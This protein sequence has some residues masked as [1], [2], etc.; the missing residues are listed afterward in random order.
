MSQAHK[1]GWGAVKQNTL[2]SS[3]RKY[4]GRTTSISYTHD[5][6][7][8]IFDR[9]LDALTWLPLK[10]WLLKSCSKAQNENT[11]QGFP[12]SFLTFL[13]SFGHSY[14]ALWPPKHLPWIMAFCTAAA[15]GFLENSFWRVWSLLLC[16]RPSRAPAYFTQLLPI[17]SIVLTSWAIGPK[18]FFTR[19]KSHRAGMAQQQN[20]PKRVTNTSIIY[21]NAPWK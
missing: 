16:C 10:M 13:R 17:L 1:I 19:Y 21:F 8:P 11:G 9:G 14:D 4:S 15:V 6:N 7:V 20:W 3:S 5:Q 18:C 12:W 2:G